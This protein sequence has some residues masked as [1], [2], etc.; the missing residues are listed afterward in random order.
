MDLTFL[1]RFS[2]NVNPEIFD[3]DDKLTNIPWITI[4]DTIISPDNWDLFWELWNKDKS[5]MAP[6]GKEDSAIWDSLCIWKSPELS[7][8]MHSSYPAKIVDWYPYFPNMIDQL[9]TIMPFSHIEKITLS[10]NKK[11][12]VP[13][14]DPAATFY[15]WPNSLRVMIY[16]TNTR[17]TFYLKKWSSLSL[18]R[19]PITSVNP[20]LR[21]TYEIEPVPY[22]E[23]MY[24]DLPETS[25]TFLFNNGE[26]L[27]GADLVDNK[28]IL[29]VWG[30]PD[31][32][33]WKSYLYR[34][35]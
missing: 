15:P 25:N 31:I 9:R 3:V 10:S 34:L 6:A 32:L 1:K 20:D 14:I 26:F 19:E 28:I 12:V 29:L 16:D 5:P 24:V 33:K 27:H 2:Y 30:I 11:A 35:L 21:Q 22:N 17:P 23:K 4:P 18:N 8:I 13:H 7:N